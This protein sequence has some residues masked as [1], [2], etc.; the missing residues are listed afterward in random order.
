MSDYK[1][2]NSTYEVRIK[3]CQML[4][5]LR[6]DINTLIYIQ[7]ITVLYNLPTSKRFDH[8]SKLIFSGRLYIFRNTS[9]SEGPNTLKM[10]HQK[11]SLIVIMKQYNM[12]NMRVSKGT[13]SNIPT[14]IANN[15]KL[16]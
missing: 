5:E 8:A 15:M 6:L 7:I 2:K 12:T 14:D 13:A 16:P 4:K 11:N 3:T 10:K 9:L 1:R